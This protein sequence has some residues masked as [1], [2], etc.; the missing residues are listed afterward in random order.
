MHP[1]RSLLFPGLLCAALLLAGCAEQKGVY[2]PFQHV[3][4]RLGGANRAFIGSVGAK[5]GPAANSFYHKYQPFWDCLLLSRTPTIGKRPDGVYAFQTTAAL[6]VVGSVAVKSG[7]KGFSGESYEIF[8]V[9]DIRDMIDQ[10]NSPRNC[11]L[12]KYLRQDEDFRIVTSMV[13][14]TSHLREIAAAVD[15]DATYRLS[16]SLDG[17][18]GIVINEGGTSG[19]PPSSDR[20]LSISDNMIHAY[21]YGRLVWDR[22]TGLVADILIDRPGVRWT[23]R[24]D[25]PPGS[26]ADPKALPKEVLAAWSA[27]DCPDPGLVWADLGYGDT[28]PGK[29]KAAPGAR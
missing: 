13:V 11:R 20:I 28:L 16:S 17:V 26:T 6:D 7:G 25:R 23:D 21:E 29:G 22:R 9:V 5:R 12:L 19:S 10:L 15:Y 14:V 18:A 2:F 1:L 27:M 24:P 4:Y 8:Q 3:N